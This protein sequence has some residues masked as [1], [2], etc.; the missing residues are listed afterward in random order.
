MTVD[1]IKEAVALKQCYAL[2]TGPLPEGYDIG[3][4]TAET[5]RVMQVVTW[6]DYEKRS[7]Y[8][9]YVG[10]AATD[11]SRPV[12]LYTSKDGTLHHGRTQSILGQVFTSAAPMPLGVVSEAPTEANGPSP[13]KLDWSKGCEWQHAEG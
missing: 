9:G 11:A 5:I 3:E 4:V 6:T 7:P 13:T 8:V 2:I 1:E 10:L 12:A